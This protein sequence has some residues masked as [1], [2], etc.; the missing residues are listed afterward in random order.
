MYMYN[1]YDNTDPHLPNI[2]TCGKKSAIKY[3]LRIS[4]LFTYKAT[5]ILSQSIRGFNAVKANMNE[6]NDVLL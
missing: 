4:H 1:K 6:R 5:L 3:I 2:Y